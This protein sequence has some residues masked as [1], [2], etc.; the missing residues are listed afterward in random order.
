MA[1]QQIIQAR[2]F[3]RNII[4]NYFTRNRFARPSRATIF[5]IALYHQV[6]Y[7]HTEYPPG[8]NSQICVSE[9]W[10][11]P[12]IFTGIEILVHMKTP[13]LVIVDESVSK[14]CMNPNGDQGD[15]RV[16]Q[17]DARYIHIFLFYTNLVMFPNHIFHFQIK[18][19]SQSRN[20][21][22]CKPSG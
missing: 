5:G 7:P 1:Q 6:N 2:N 15:I 18:H 13:A 17:F 21:N 19:Q 12:A 4:F 16:I 22:C 14:R 10:F 9:G 8:T 20:G 3:G 11:N